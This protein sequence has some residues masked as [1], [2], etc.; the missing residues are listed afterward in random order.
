[1]DGVNGAMIHIGQNGDTL[2]YES[3]FARKQTC[4]MHWRETGLGADNG[5]QFVRQY[6][7]IKYK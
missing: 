5:D 3:V 1:M 7:F 4:R 6:D 2:A